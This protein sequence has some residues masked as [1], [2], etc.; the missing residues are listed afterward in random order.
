MC[1]SLVDRCQNPAWG[2]EGKRAG[3]ASLWPG[4]R[5][6]CGGPAITLRTQNLSGLPTDLIWAQGNDS[7]GTL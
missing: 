5:G 2:T 6:A 3:L 1:V 7:V 4:S